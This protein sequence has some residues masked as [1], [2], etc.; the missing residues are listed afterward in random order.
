[1]NKTI[2][3][4]ILITIILLSLI[5]CSDKNKSDNSE[6]LNYSKEIVNGITT[7]VND[8]KPSEPSL[9]IELKKIAEISGLNED[10]IDS[11]LFVRAYDI[12]MDDRGNF[13]ILDGQKSHIFIFSNTGTFIKKFGREGSGPGEFN[14]AYS[15]LVANDFIYIPDFSS[16]KIS[17]FD[18]EGT[19]S[20]NMTFENMSIP[21]NLI[22]FGENKFVGSQGFGFSFTDG[23][24]KN[25][26]SLEIYN[27]DFS[28]VK[29]VIDY[30]DELDFSK[31]FNPLNIQIPFGCSDKEIFLSEN[32][33]DNYQINVLDEFGNKNRIIKKKYRKIRRSKQ[34]RKEFQ[35]NNT[36]GFSV[37]GEAKQLKADAEYK[38]AIRT[39][40]ID[41][42]DRIW[43]AFSVDEKE[44]LEGRFYDIFSSEGIFLNRV[45]IDVEKDVTIHFLKDKIVTYDNDLNIIKAYDY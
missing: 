32:N 6:I 40:N 42:L 45:K 20:E 38:K 34:E 25:R 35:E 43:I 36:F 17:K 7:I 29:Q 1:M 13:Y 28:I 3:Y 22:K 26:I 9:N 2:Y 5:G 16:S 33:D 10:S 41:K 21:N 12:Q 27:K 31:P 15:F 44:K 4:S 11:A 8:N 23:I 24:W 30:E 18:L 14:N 37:N 19:F 39:L